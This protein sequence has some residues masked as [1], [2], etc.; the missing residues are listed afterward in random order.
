MKIPVRVD[1]RVE[2]ESIA[3]AR[4]E[5][6]YIDVRVAGGLAL[7]PQKQCILGALAFAGWFFFSLQVTRKQELWL[8]GQSKTRL[9]RV[10]II[11]A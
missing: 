1:E 8:W 7:A 10:L 9:L 11:F 3:P 2:A 5:V 4:A 6:L